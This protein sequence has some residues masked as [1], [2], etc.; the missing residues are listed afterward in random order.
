VQHASFAAP[1]AH[2]HPSFFSPSQSEKPAAQFPY[3]HA[4][5]AHVI[6]VAFF[7]VVLQFVVQLPHWV[8]LVAVFVSQ[9]L[10]PVPQWLKP[11]LHVQEQ[12]P[13]E[14]DGVPLT[15]EHTKLHWPQFATSV[16]E[17][18]QA[19]AQQSGFDPEHARPQPLQL[20]TSV[21]GS[22]QNPV[23]QICPGIGQVP[24][25]PLH[26]SAQIPEGE[27]SWLTFGQ[28][29]LLRQATHW[30]RVVWQYGAAWLSAKQPWSVEHPGAHVLTVFVDAS[31]PAARQNRPS[32]Q[33]SGSV[34]HSAHAFETHF[35]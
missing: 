8:T 10:L 24:P 20:R 32:G 6:P 9:P 29:A 11:V 25:S 18:L 17:L 33:L 7:T 31:P 16:R 27:Q 2:S 3:V 5:A 15:A 35:L 4:L 23:Q 28:L 1:H 21:F 34:V 30:C 13:A 14:Q 12:L 22:T 26:V 19:P